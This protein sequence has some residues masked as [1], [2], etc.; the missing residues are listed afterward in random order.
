MLVVFLLL[1]SC[2][3]IRSG[4]HFC[5]ISEGL[6]TR[7]IKHEERRHLA[8]L[9]ACALRE[10]VARTL[11]PSGVGAWAPEAEAEAEDEDGA[12]SAKD[13]LQEARK[14]LARL[15]HA[16]LDRVWRTVLEGALLEARCGE[17]CTARR[18]LEYLMTHVPWYGPI[19]HEALRLEE[20][21]E[22]PLAALDIV[23]RGLQE[24][25]R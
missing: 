15:Q 2:C 19:Y 10:A 25:P 9:S 23:C 3:P 24:I 1:L 16:C 8:H 22:R 7:A 18:V 11:G 14:L 5:D 6:L 20:K 17:V 13:C 12:E 21:A 4:L